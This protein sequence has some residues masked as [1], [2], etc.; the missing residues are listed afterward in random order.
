M[1]K[2][3]LH[4]FGQNF[5]HPRVYIFI[6]LGSAIIFLTFFTTNN[7]LEIAISGIASVFIGI[8][9]NNF[10]SLETHQ[11]DEQTIKAKV[12]HSLKVMEMAHAKIENMETDLTAENYQQ[13]K[14]KLTELKQLISLVTQLLIQEELLN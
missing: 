7:A 5:L 11:K 10:S 8:G 4:R 13:A 9:V 3:Y 14:A 1:L 2:K 12:G 6:F